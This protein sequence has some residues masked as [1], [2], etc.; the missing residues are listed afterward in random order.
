MEQ[1][2]Q[3]SFLDLLLNRTENDGLKLQIYRKPTHTDQYLKFS[4]QHPVGHK[5]SVVR[6]LLERSQCLVTE[7]ED[8]KQEDFHLEEALRA[9]GY[10]KWT[11]NKVRHHIESKRDNLRRQESNMILRSGQW[12]LFLMWE[13]VQ[14]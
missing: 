2:G 12:S 4:S 5:L 8:R 9:C 14:E 13:T 1:G 6:T 11:L 3:L 7:I 10:L